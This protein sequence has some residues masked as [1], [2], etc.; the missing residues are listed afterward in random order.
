[1]FYGLTNAEPSHNREHNTR[2]T[3]DQ[4]R[5]MRTLNKI[6]EFLIELKEHR[7]AV[8]RQTVKTLKGQA[9][10]GDVNGA[11]KGLH[12]SL[13]K[14]QSSRERLLNAHRNAR[15]ITKQ[16]SE[17]NYHSQLSISLRDSR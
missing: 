8:P 15:Y 14:Q 9:L 16:Y 13:K 4:A 6:G 2:E 7:H 5:R 1:M 11:R 17:V 3:E 10:A 12:A